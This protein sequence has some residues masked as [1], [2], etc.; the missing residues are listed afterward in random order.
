M[1]TGK[2]A[3]IAALWLS[4]AAPLLPF[5]AGCSNGAYTRGAGQSVAAEPYRQPA[6]PYWYTRPTPLYSASEQERICTPSPELA[7]IITDQEVPGVIGTAQGKCA[8]FK[9]GAREVD[10]IISLGPKDTCDEAG[11]TALRVNLPRKAPVCS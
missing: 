10:Y 1:H 7:V 9:P 8:V 6:R 11:L 5:L 2:A 3:R 4:L